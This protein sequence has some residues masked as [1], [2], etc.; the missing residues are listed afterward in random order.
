MVK[1]QYGAVSSVVGIAFIFSIV[2]NLSGMSYQTDG[3][4]VCTD[5]Y[6]KIEVNSTYWNICVE[7]AGDKTA[8]FKKSVYGRVLYINLDKIN[9]VI[10][11]NPEIKTY[12]LVQTIKSRAEFTSE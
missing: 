1:W 11:T 6:S 12:L 4:K 2:L 5:C 3:D 10:T 8:I 9:E 7:H